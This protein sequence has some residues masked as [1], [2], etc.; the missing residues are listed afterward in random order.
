M[1]NE[2]ASK[3]SN[4]FVYISPVRLPPLVPPL[5][6]IPAVMDNVA[7]LLKV[8]YALS[9]SPAILST[10]CVS[11]KALS[12]YVLTS[13]ALGLSTFAPTTIL[14]SLPLLPAYLAVA[15]VLLAAVASADTS[16]YTSTLVACK[17]ASLRLRMRSS[18]T[19]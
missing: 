16:L 3:L 10:V 7:E 9:F 2:Y 4:A 8:T 18:S 13:K 1:L 15:S 5:R 6:G 14:I 12:R 11:T 19:L 17:K